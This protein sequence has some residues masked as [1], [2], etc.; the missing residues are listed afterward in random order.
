MMEIIAYIFIG[1]SMVFFGIGTF[2]I[3]D[4][5]KTFG[6]YKLHTES[7]VIWGM[8]VLWIGIGVYILSVWVI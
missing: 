1:F 4:W 6:V 7:I 8:G 2:F 3:F 5:K